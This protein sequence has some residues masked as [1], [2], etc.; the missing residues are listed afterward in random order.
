MPGVRI[1][2]A[3][4]RNCVTTVVHPRPYLAPLLCGA[5]KRTHLTKTYH[6]DVDDDGCSIVSQ[7]VLH[8]LKEAGAIGPEGFEIENEVKDPPTIRLNL[9]AGNVTVKV[10]AHIPKGP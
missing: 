7:L 5:C 4:L 10:V 6:L 1:R 3:S 8:R 2:H 9:G